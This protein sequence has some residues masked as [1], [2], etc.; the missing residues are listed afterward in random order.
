MPLTVLIIVPLSIEQ[1]FKMQY[2]FT[3]AP[4][5]FLIFLGLFIMAMTISSFIKMGKGTLAPWSPTKKLV[6]AGLYGYVRNPMILG[7]LIVLIGESI[8]FLS[9]NIFVWAVIFF[10]INNIYFSLYEEPNLEERFGDEY[11]EYKKNVPR[12]IPRRKPYMPE[13]RYNI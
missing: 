6:S 3:S 5:L 13:K 2:M 8:L 12:W 4:G 10:L 1:N 7:V 9:V 11:R